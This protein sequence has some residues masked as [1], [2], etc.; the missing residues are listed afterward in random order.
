MN[1]TETFPI[2]RQALGGQS[3]V[4]A[5]DHRFYHG[6]TGAVLRLRYGAESCL[7]AVFGAH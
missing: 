5:S 6:G 7:H 4:S 1:P 2:N 3:A